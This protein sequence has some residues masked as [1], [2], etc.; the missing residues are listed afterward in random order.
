MK[1]RDWCGR[2][3]EPSGGERSRGRSCRIEDHGEELVGFALVMRGVE[4]LPLLQLAYCEVRLIG[5]L[6]FAKLASSLRPASS[7]FS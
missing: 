6:R 3:S 4:A 2:Y 1:N 5:V 7:T